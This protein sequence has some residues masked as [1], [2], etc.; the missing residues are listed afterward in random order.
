MCVIKKGIIVTSV[1]KKMYTLV[2][3]LNGQYNQEKRK[4][5]EENKYWEGQ[6]NQYL[7]YN[8]FI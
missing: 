1:N 3:R 4:E 2:H 8:N 5:K 7:K 6:Y